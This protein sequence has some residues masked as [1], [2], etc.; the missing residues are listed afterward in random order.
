MSISS[1]KGSSLASCRGA[2]SIGV[3]DPLA[4]HVWWKAP[5]VDRFTLQAMPDNSNH[6]GLGALSFDLTSELPW[7]PPMTT[8]PPPNAEDA[9]A[10]DIPRPQGASYQGFYKQIALKPNDTMD[11]SLGASG[12]QLA[13]VPM[14][15][16][17]GTWGVSII[18]D[19]SGLLN[20]D[21]R[22]SNEDTIQSTP[23]LILLDP[24]PASAVSLSD[25]SIQDS[26]QKHLLQHLLPYG[27]AKSLPLIYLQIGTM[28]DSGLIVIRFTR[29]VMEYC[30]V[31]IDF[32]H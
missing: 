19:P 3:V 20:R 12:L 8:P 9:T 25:P 13:V 31:C 32:R 26:W 24:T 18:V 11:S 1:G 15:M 2:C 30:K 7:M 10:T 14:L 29:L 22:S 27:P 6:Q 16:M 17:S 23:F 28:G 5:L 21:M 4:F